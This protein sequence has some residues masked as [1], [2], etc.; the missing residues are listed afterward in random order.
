MLYLRIDGGALSYSFYA[1]FY[2][3]VVVS[4]LY[5]PASLW[6]H[7]LSSPVMRYLGKI[8]Y[9]TYLVHHIV[10]RLVFQ[11]VGV[12][13]SSVK[14]A[15]VSLVLAAAAT[16]AISAASFRFLEGPLVRRGHRYSY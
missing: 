16:L 8:S 2:G 6:A 7:F 3:A 9:C 10:L 12:S 5:N 4:A 11:W 14:L 1:L 13:R 15:L